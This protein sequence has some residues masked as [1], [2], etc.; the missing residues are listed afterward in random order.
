MN[1]YIGDIFYK[2]IQLRD[3]DVYCYERGH[4]FYMTDDC[5][6]KCMYCDEIFD[7]I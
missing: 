1:Y 6:Y 2:N 7:K 3:K 5:K 4:D